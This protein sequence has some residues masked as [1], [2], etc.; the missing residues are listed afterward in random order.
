MIVL[1]VEVYRADRKRCGLDNPSTL[2]TLA[3]EPHAG[4]AHGSLALQF[5]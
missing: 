1:G 3:R 5:T 2:D 4:A